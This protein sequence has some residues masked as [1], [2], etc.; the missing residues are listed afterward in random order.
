MATTCWMLFALTL[1]ASLI[2]GAYPL[3]ETEALI[4]FKK[5]LADPLNVLKTWDASQP[6]P[7]SWEHITCND[8]NK[9]NGVFLTKSQLTGQLVPELGSL[10][11]LHQMILDQNEISGPIPAELG[12]LSILRGLV[13]SYNGLTGSIPPSLGNLNYLLTFQLDHNQLSGKIPSEIALIK[14]LQIAAF[15]DN[16]DLCW[17]FQPTPI[18]KGDYPLC[19][20]MQ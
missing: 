9:V 18:F 11:A 20:K 13:L 7:C 5:S 16:N 4:A 15:N 14:S 12:N 6:N 3:S 19:Q 1:S 2:P 10:S 17:D 8:Q